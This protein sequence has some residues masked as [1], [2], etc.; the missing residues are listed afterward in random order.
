MVTIKDQ[1][2]IDDITPEAIAKRER[3]ESKVHPC[4]NFFTTDMLIEVLGGKKWCELMDFLDSLSKTDLL[5]VDELQESIRGQMFVY[6]RDHLMSSYLTEY[7]GE[8]E[9]E[10]LRSCYK[11][12]EGNVCIIAPPMT[13]YRVPFIQLYY[14]GEKVSPDKM[15]KSLDFLLRSNLIYPDDPKDGKIDVETDVILRA[16]RR[17]IKDSCSAAVSVSQENHD[18][19]KGNCPV[20]TFYGTSEKKDSC[21]TPITITYVRDRELNYSLKE[22]ISYNDATSDL[23]LPKLPIVVTGTSSSDFL[24]LYHRLVRKADTVSD[25]DGLF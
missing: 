1:Y 19:S 10:G 25:L 5:N 23:R 12:S 8:P 18:Q 22:V 21:F 11:D 2:K 24:H 6:E 13:K 16:L 15:P 4:H 17:T 7:L 20:V 3:I 14:T 9:S